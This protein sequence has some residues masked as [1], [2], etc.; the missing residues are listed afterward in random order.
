M[1]PIV[2]IQP[3]PSRAATRAR[4]RACMGTSIVPLPVPAPAMASVPSQSPSFPAPNGPFRV[5][6]P[7]S[8]SEL[9]NVQPRSAPPKIAP[10]AITAAGPSNNAEPNL[11]P[12]ITSHT[13]AEPKLMPKPTL[14]ELRA[15][16][17]QIAANFY[18]LP[19]HKLP[20]FIQ[21]IVWKS[22]M[23]SWHST[24]RRM[25]EHNMQMRESRPKGFEQQIK[26]KVVEKGKGKGRAGAPRWT[27]SFKVS[28]LP[29]IDYLRT[30]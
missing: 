26:G 16:R 11:M 5:G 27:A 8:A 3:V 30:L 2:T 14:Y 4:A 7:Q 22:T 25:A 10:F 28:L 13:D 17:L 15:K 18:R 24:F 19:V 6:R 23:N 20:R 21:D 29:F 12:K 1:A 9:V